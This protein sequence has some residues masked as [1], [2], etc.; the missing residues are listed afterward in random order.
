MQSVSSSSES[1]PERLLAGMRAVLTY[2]PG[3]CCSLPLSAA[4][5]ATRP[6]DPHC[7]AYPVQFHFTLFLSPS[8][9][10]WSQKRRCNCWLRPRLPLL[11]RAYRNATIHRKNIFLHFSKLQMHHTVLFVFHFIFPAIYQLEIFNTSD[12]GA[13]VEIQTECLNL[14]LE[15]RLLVVHHEDLFF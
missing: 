2:S 15:Y 10:C 5:I 6:I 8:C 13:T 3:R 7:S 1:S 12:S 4:V 14:S 11:L 9:M